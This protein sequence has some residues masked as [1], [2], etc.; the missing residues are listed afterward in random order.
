MIY[1]DNAATTGKKPNEVIKAVMNGLKNYSA[2][3]GRGGHKAS[4]MAASAVY[5]VRSKIKEYFN[6][7][8]ENAVCFTSGCTASINTILYGLLEKGDHVIVSSLEHNAVMRPI[9]ALKEK[10][11]IEVDIA[12]IDLSD[13]ESSVLQFEKKIKPNTKMIFTTHASNVTGTVL[14]IKKIGKL[15]KAN[16]LRFAVDAAQ[17]AGHCQIDMHGMGIDYLAIAAHKGIYGPMGVGVLIAEN[18]VDD[19]LIKGGTGVNSISMQQPDALPERIESGTLNLPGILGS[20]A[21]IDFVSRKE[22]KRM[23]ENEN[24]LVLFLWRELNKI[25]AKLYIDFESQKNNV[26]VISFNIHGHSSEETAEFLSR[27]DIAV[28]GG[29]HCAPSAHKML[30]TLDSGTVRVSTSVFNNY[31]EIEKLIYLL[32][33]FK[34]S[35]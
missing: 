10:K 22:I 11:G 34:N 16:N 17:S 12:E 9:H 5:G 27:N 1:L 18:S 31:V 24:K 30:G 20:G 26:P 6:T 7:S 21:G 33:K 25:G 2:N 14:P 32:K 29:L 28:R 23:V 4:I 35:Y 3:A 19:V 8:N 15:C 13:P